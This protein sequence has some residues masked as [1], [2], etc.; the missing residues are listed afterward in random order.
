MVALTQG[1][2]ETARA[3][4]TEALALLGEHDPYRFARLWQGELAC[5]AALAG[6]PA[7]AA[8]WLAEMDRRVDEANRLFEPRLELCRAWVAAGPGS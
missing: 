3:S 7:G 6:D 4:L 8:R 1:L 2:V 5:A